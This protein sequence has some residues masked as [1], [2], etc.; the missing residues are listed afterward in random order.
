[1]QELLSQQG[2][3]TVRPLSV[4]MIFE[5]NHNWD[6]FS[7]ANKS[8][9]RDVEI[10][11]VNK[12]MSCKD[13]NRGFF[14]YH[15]EHCGTDLIVYF[16]CNSRICTN[17]GKNHT[18]KW[19]KSL[20]KAL[21]NVPHRH[22]VLT[23]PDVLWTIV[24]ANR[25][26][27]K[28]LMDAAIKA[29]ND[30]ISY[31]HRNGRLLA[32]A[33][34]VLHPFSKNLGFNPH[35]HVLVTEGGFDKNNKFIHQKFIS[36]RAMRKTWQYQVLTNF[37]AAFLGDREFSM[38][39]N[40]L[41]KKYPEGFYVH[42]PEE[43]RITNKRKIAR[44]VARYIRHPAVS[45]TRLYRYNGKSVIFWYK[46]HEDK[47]LFVTMEVE[48]FITAL[49]Q[50]IPDRNFKMIRYYGAYGRRIKKRYS[51]YLQRSLNQLTFADFSKIR[52][53]WTP[54]CPNCGE[55]MSFEYYE[56]GPPEEKVSFGS[57]LLDWKHPMLSHCYN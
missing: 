49:I 34:V 57:K 44:Y 9:L 25:F 11:E 53:T 6:A 10:K 15:C 39:V 28:V 48:E 40:H 26:L 47:R 16:G 32:G 29:I 37:K 33:I 24:R 19:A 7:L 46:N 56:K 22:A 35:L 12:M 3:K 23:I 55:K 4:R 50:H 45:N 36:F 41:F 43:S 14:K 51:G 18:D 13:E 5:D 1:M 8:I 21:F 31:K 42:L 30:T 17:C 54:I 38:L 52:N 27:H 2:I 20:E